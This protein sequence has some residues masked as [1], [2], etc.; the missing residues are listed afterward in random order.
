MSEVKYN[1]VTAS[2]KRKC[3]EMARS[4]KTYREIYTEYYSKHYDTKYEGFRSMIKRWKKK[5][6]ADDELLESGNLGYG[7]QAHA[8]TVQLNKDGEIIQS[9]IKS[10]SEDNLYLE[11]IENIKNLDI[12]VEVPKSNREVTDRMLEITFDDMHFGIAK[13][14]D[15]EGT[16]QETIEIIEKYQRKEI[17]IVIGEDLLHTE[18]LKGYTSNG[19]FIG[20]IDIVTAYN[21]TLRFYFAIMEVAIKSAEMVKVTYSMGNHSETLSW[22]ILQVLKVKYPQAVYDDTF[23]H[24]KVLTYGKVF[25]G[26][27]HGDTI[28]GNLR[29]IKELFIEENAI[30]YAHAKVREIHVGHLHHQKETGDLNGCIVRRLS[31]KVPTDKWHNKHGYTMAV[32]R[33]QLFEYSEDRLLSIYYV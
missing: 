3:V 16:L 8:T 15:Y 20:E 31:T 23:E 9:W 33:F 21:D 4:G 11:L 2:V 6:H 29:D 10:R 18:T 28:K 17:N 24:R 1:N 30:A 27:T 19:T 14:E 26:L 13:Y 12:A 25:I 32:K 5:T 22:T 7:F